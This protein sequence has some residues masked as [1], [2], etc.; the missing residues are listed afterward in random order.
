MTIND[1]HA[2]GPEPRSEEEREKRWA[3]MNRACAESD[4]RIRAE[5]AARVRASLDRGFADQVSSDL[6]ARI[7]SERERHTGYVL[8]VPP[9]TE[10]GSLATKADIARLSA[11]QLSLADDATA[12][13]AEIGHCHASIATLARNAQGML[14]VLVICGLLATAALVVACLR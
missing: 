7:K 4:A 10:I 11:G 12:M 6:L 13:R 9:G 2:A 8:S 3:E 5:S 14:V 1:P